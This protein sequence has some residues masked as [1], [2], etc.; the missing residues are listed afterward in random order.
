MFALLRSFSWQEL[1]QHPWRTLTA[2]AAIM[3]GV[4]LGF[5][6]HVIN[7]STLDEI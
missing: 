5:A 4:A 3:L 1:C 7:Q 6:V 2:L